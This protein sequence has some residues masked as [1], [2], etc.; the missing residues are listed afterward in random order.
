MTIDKQSKRAARELAA[1]EGI[2]YTAARR[3]LS[4]PDSDQADHADSL[5]GDVER[6]DPRA[7]LLDWFDD[8][9]GSLEDLVDEL[10]AAYADDEGDERSWTRQYYEDLAE[11]AIETVRRYLRN[12][13][14]KPGRT[15]P[16]QAM[17]EWFSLAD[18]YEETPQPFTMLWTAFQD[19]PWGLTSEELAQIALRTV[20]WYLRDSAAKLNSGQ[21]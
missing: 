10:V 6:T 20:Q 9:A 12:Q 21:P 15:D 18:A 11:I 5:T 19:D 16:R 13:E 3:R 1:R 14:V 8:T 17:T 2:S 7:V 4:G